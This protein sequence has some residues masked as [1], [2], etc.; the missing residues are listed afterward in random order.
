KGRFLQD[1]G[2][3]LATCGDAAT[4]CYAFTIPKFQ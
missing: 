1:D 2:T 3:F 4:K